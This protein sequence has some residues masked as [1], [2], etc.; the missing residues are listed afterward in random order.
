[1]ISVIA[2]LQQL[3]LQGWE[4]HV[5]TRPGSVPYLQDSKHSRSLSWNL[6]HIQEPFLGKQEKNT[7]LCTQQ[8]QFLAWNYP[9][10]TQNTVKPQY[11]GEI[12]ESLSTSSWNSE[13]R[14]LTYTLTSVLP[15]PSHLLPHPQITW[16]ETQKEKRTL[17][18][19]PGIPQLTPQI[20]ILQLWAH[21]SVQIMNYDSQPQNNYT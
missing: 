3:L 16:K 2:C 14:I 6:A 17:R 9:K 18:R 19:A 5:V 1:M 4:G 11:G 7:T 8:Q 15:Q 12:S 13:P 21:G 20:Q 10:R